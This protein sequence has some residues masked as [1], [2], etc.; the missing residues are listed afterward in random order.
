MFLSRNK[1]KYILQLAEKNA[2]SRHMWALYKP[3]IDHILSNFLKTEYAVGTNKKY[4][5]K[6]VGTHQKCLSE[7]LP[8]SI[9][10]MLMW[11]NKKTIYLIPSNLKLWS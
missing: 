6:A 7:M 9:H 11:T 8:M 10:N 1:K 4:L 2:L 3:E 5:S